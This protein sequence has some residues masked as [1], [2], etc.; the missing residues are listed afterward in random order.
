[1]M[2]LSASANTADVM[3]SYDAYGRDQLPFAQV[4]ALTRTAQ[5]V[6]AA[7]EREIRDSFDRPT[8]YT[9]KALFMRPATKANREAVVWLKD[10][11][12][13]SGTPADVYLGPEIEGGGRKLKNFEL[14][15][16][17]AGILPAGMFAVPGRAA[18]IDAYGN[19]NRGQL[20]QLLSYFRT[21]GTAGYS[22]NITDAKKAKLARGT[23]S[24]QGFAY[25]VGRPGDG[26]AP[27]GIYQRVNFA[28]GTALQPLLIFVDGARY[29][30]IFD[31]WSAARLTFEREWPGQ[32]RQALSEA[33]ASTI[34]PQLPR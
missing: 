30:G 1:M 26:K 12:A 29:R 3:K 20:V 7:E 2:T 24:K 15:L 33:T 13:G 25:F 16:R 4:L 6:K 17:S 11:R 28:H 19:M 10:D 34:G 32:I 9:Q 31:F 27:L 8:P 23:K 5:L 18:K 21:F 22:A 14:A